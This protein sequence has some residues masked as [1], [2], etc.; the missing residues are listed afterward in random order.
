MLS[1]VNVMKHIGYF[2]E[3]ESFINYIITEFKFNKFHSCIEMLHIAM[4]LAD[5]YTSYGK[6]SQS[7]KMCYEILS[8]RENVLGSSHPDV[9]YT[10]NAIGINLMRLN[11]YSQETYHHFNRAINIA[12]SDIQSHKQFYSC[13]LAAAIGNYGCLLSFRGEY[14]KGLHY[15][16]QSL[17]MERKIL[18]GFH[19]NLAITYHDIALTYRKWVETKNP[20]RFYKRRYI[21]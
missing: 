1:M 13:N 16:I 15:L 21:Q 2:K 9:G 17:N 11:N 4:T 3:S 12:I 8:M 7:L 6:Y 18:G 19:P 20:K 10:C 5:L 14:E